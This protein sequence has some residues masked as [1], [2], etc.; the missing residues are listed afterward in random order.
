MKKSTLLSVLAVALVVF[1]AGV[2]YAKYDHAEPEIITISHDMD[3]EAKEEALDLM[4][5]LVGLQIMCL[6]S[7]GEDSDEIF[8][9]E[10]DRVSDWLI[11]A[12]KDRKYNAE[13]VKRLHDAFN[14]AAFEVQ[15]ARLTGEKD[16]E[17]LKDCGKFD[18]E[19]AR[20]VLEEE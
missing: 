10:M 12:L 13:E 15:F 5:K 16:K 14:A 6:K 9:R 2:F 17:F 11:Q 7:K 3:F 1:A 18:V 20:F 4:G 19:Y 8:Q